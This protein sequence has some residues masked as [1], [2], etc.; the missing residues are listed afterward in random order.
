MAR[1]KGM[2]RIEK[3]R[4]IPKLSLPRG[5]LHHRL[6][7]WQRVQ[8]LTHFPL[9]KRA[10]TLNFLYIKRAYQIWHVS[11]LI[12]KIR[13]VMRPCIAVHCLRYRTKRLVGAAVKMGPALYSRT[14]DK[15]SCMWDSHFLQTIP[16]KWNIILPLILNWISILRWSLCPTRYDGALLIRSR[17]SHYQAYTWIHLFLNKPLWS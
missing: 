16:S 15:T 11:H 2:Y 4:R 5:A 9:L 14:T 1:R 10:Q 6:G 17:D 7:D 8:L 13:E 12:S 3:R